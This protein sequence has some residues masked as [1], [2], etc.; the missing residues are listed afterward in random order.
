MAYNIEYMPE[1]FDDIDD[2]LTYL[3]SFYPNTAASFSRTLEH[4]INQLA[5]QP[6]IAELW[7][8]DQDFRKLIVG[9][10]LVFYMVYDDKNTVEIH[11]VLRGTWNIRQL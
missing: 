1:S 11:R 4:R 8:H 10:Y 3:S 7:E 9:D 2:A 6:Y 5:D